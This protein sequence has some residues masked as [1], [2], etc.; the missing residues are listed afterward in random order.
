MSALNPNDSLNVFGRVI[1]LNNNVIAKAISQ[2]TVT[3]EQSYG[4]QCTH[5]INIPVTDGYFQTSLSKPSDGRSFK[6][7]VRLNTDADY[8]SVETYLDAWNYIEQTELFM[9]L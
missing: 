8:V 3:M 5:S 9:H 6:T 4:N 1:D 7:K 2:M